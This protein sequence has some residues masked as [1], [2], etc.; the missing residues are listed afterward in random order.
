[1]KH[2]YDLVQVNTDDDLI[3]SG[4]YQAGDKDKP[5]VTLV[6]GFT[7]DF[8]THKFY[9]SIAEKLK[10]NQMGLVL[11]Q[12]RGTGL[13]TKFYKSKGKSLHIGSYYEKLEE[14]HLDISAFVEFLK[15]E[16]YT[17]I[18]LAGH[19]LGTIKA[20]RYLF[21]GKFRQDIT[22]MILL[23][24]FDKNVFMEIKA[25]DK[26]EEYLE[27]ARSIIQSGKGQDLVP[28]PEYEDF[29]MTYETFLS[30]YDKTDLNSI[31][32]FYRAKDYHFPILKQIKI[33]VLAVL[34]D[35]DEFVN[36]PD[37][38]VSAQQALATI[39]SNIPTSQTL[40]LESTGHTY[41]GKESELAKSVGDFLS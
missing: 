29:P 24:P 18:V 2:N 4:L 15:A 20:V 11:A 19:S 37:Y 23:A 6:H 31:W 26:L 34:G 10:Q 36:Y 21:E 35:Q 27:V 5:V 16:G 1:M 41:K 22:K 13:H 30:W 9:H 28:V 14:A 39:E 38:G 12:S 25:G 3:L 17:N 7:G 8:Y 40:L 33:P 32:D